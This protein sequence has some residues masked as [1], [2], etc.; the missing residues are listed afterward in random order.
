MAIVKPIATKT[1]LLYIY[2]YSQRLSTQFYEDCL[3]YCFCEIQRAKSQNCEQ[4][5]CARSQNDEEN[6]T[7]CVMKYNG[8][9]NIYSAK[10]N[11]GQ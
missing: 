8:H 10:L 2:I 7:C 1:V 5:I 11:I 4:K 6:I 9:G 3:A